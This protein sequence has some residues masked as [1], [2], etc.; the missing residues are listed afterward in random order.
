MLDR[1]LM[2]NTNIFSGSG[3]ATYCAIASLRLMGF[4]GDDCLANAFAPRSQVDIQS[5]LDWS[6]QVQYIIHT[7]FLATV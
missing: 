1:L 4:I 2:T 7:C 6:L 3:G 5:L